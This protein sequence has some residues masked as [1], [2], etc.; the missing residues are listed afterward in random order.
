M[1]YSKSNGKC[2]YNLF[3]RLPGLSSVGSSHLAW[4]K[5]VA[6]NISWAVLMSPILTNLIL[7]ETFTYRGDSMLIEFKPLI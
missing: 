6:L 3:T 5:A 7:T 4:K 2:Y 1:H